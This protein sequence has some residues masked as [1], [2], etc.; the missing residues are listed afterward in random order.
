MNN[1]PALSGVVMDP[2]EGISPQKDSTLAMLLAAQAR[3]HRIVY[4]QQKDLHINQGVAAG[5]GRFLTVK[6]SLEDFFEM[7]QEPGGEPVGDAFLGEDLVIRH[8]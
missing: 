7:V 4:F 8:S 3:G 5:E 6:D 1:S 2:I